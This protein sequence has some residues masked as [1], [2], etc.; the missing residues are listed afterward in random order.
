MSPPFPFEAGVDPSIFV[1]DGEEEE[2]EEEVL[3]IGGGGDVIIYEEQK[4]HFI[5]ITRIKGE[6]AR[7]RLRD[8][9]HVWSARE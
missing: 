7:P 5:I 6:S 8:S 2:E 9:S 3:R 1:L 4:L